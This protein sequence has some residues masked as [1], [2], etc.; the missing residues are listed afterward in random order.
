MRNSVAVY[1]P[2]EIAVQVGIE[3][4]MTLFCYV[5]NGTVCFERVDRGVFSPGVVASVGTE[6]SRE[7][8]E[9]GYAEAKKDLGQSR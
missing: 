9:R 7:Y 5:V 2:Q 4:H 3:P 8:L 6:K 1:I